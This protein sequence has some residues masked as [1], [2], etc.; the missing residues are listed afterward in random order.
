MGDFED[1]GHIDSPDC[2]CHPYLWMEGDDDDG[3]CVHRDFNDPDM[4]P[5]SNVLVQ[6]LRY[7]LLDED[8]DKNSKHYY[9]ISKRN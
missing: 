3:I 8:D 6:A 1:A 7:F 2:Q 9:Y 4:L 5:P